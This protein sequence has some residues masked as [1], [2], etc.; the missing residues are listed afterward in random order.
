[1]VRM[2]LTDSIAYRQFQY[3]LCRV[4][5]MVHDYDV[6]FLDLWLFQYSLCRVVLMVKLRSQ[7]VSFFDMRFQYSLCRVVLMVL[8]HHD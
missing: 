8:R 6:G 5:L 7:K 3:S 4:V 1:M 2:D